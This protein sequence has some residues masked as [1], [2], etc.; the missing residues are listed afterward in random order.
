MA[1]INLDA[2]LTACDQLAARIATIGGEYRGSAYIFDK[3]MR[4]F[5]NKALPAEAV[6]FAVH[7]AAPVGRDAEATIH[8][9][10]RM[11]ITLV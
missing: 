10:G 8:R 4:A 6:T 2:I 9:D 5:T 3:C 11:E 1:N 7:I